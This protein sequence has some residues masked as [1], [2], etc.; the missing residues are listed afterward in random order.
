MSQCMH[1]NHRGFLSTDKNTKNT[2]DVLTYGFNA[3]YRRFELCDEGLHP[4]RPKRKVK[5]RVRRAEADSY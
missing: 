3:V 4:T 1:K 2:T 5:R